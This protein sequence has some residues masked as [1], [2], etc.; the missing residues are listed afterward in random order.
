MPKKKSLTQTISS[1]KN[2]D[3]DKF[4]EKKLLSGNIKF[5]PQD[6][7]PFSPALQEVLSVPGV[8]VGHVTLL[9]GHSD[10]GKT[11]ALLELAVSAQKMG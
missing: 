6:W 7:I 2:F 4:K 3:L 10:T 5:K 1:A 8:P 11:T 9:R